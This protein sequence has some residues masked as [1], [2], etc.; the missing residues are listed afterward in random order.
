M[1]AE[2]D[3]TIAACGRGRDAAI[4]HNIVLIIQA[5]HP[6]PLDM[7]EANIDQYDKLYQSKMDLYDRF[8]CG[9]DTADKAYAKYQEFHDWMLATVERQRLADKGQQATQQQSSAHPKH[10]QPGKFATPGDPSPS[11]Q[12]CQEL[13][14]FLNAKHENMQQVNLVNYRYCRCR[15]EY[16][17]ST[18]HES[19]YD[20]V[21]GG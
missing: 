10:G 12:Y 20:C 4:R 7:M 13:Q 16:L 2:Q 3:A 14:D 11:I 18:S 9:A 6:G 8:G 21:S 5:T 17:S 1:Y 15:V 19:R